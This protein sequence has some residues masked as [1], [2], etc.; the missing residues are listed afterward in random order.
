MVR[1]IFI[2]SLGFMER[3]LTNF[4]LKLQW[5]AGIFNI[6]ILILVG[7]IVFAF[8]QVVIYIIAGILCG[9]TSTALSLRMKRWSPGQQQLFIVI[10]NFFFV[11]LFLSCDGFS[12][13]AGPLNV[14]LGSLLSV[15][16]YR[17]NIIHKTSIFILPKLI[18]LRKILAN[19][20]C[21]YRYALR[22]RSIII[23]L[24]T[25]RRRNRVIIKR[26]EAAARRRMKSATRITYLLICAQIITLASIPGCIITA[27]YLIF[28]DFDRLYVD[29]SRYPS[30]DGDKV[31][32]I[33]DRLPEDFFGGKKLP[34]YCVYQ[35]V[36]SGHSDIVC[37][38]TEKKEAY[39][40]SFNTEACKFSRSGC[41]PETTEISRSKVIKESDLASQ[42]RNEQMIRYTYTLTAWML[43]ISSALSPI[44]IPTLRWLQWRSTEK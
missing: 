36:F 34:L 12:Y 1:H 24:A 11:V 21:R 6:F 16:E 2:D 40:K 4:L 25:Y 30:V 27:G 10:L 9:F 18:S 26:K 13:R 15:V 7:N 33:K 3:D 8:L 44:L 19:L 23:F 43:L 42:V 17:M 35:E 20:F 22:P 31:I 32:D 14:F 38:Y 5:L 28:R 41:L 29:K 37:I 39:A